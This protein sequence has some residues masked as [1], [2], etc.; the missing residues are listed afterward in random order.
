MKKY[1][2][3]LNETVYQLGTKQIYTETSKHRQ[4]AGGVIVNRVTCPVTEAN[5]YVISTPD[6]LKFLPEKNLTRRREEL[7]CYLVVS[8]V[9][10]FV[11][12][13]EKPEVIPE[14]SKMLVLWG[15]L[16]D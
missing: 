2:F 13:T 3:K 5:L 10:K 6:G 16:N 15:V 12:H 11:K 14:G 1:K 8:D 7:L 4:K 9:G